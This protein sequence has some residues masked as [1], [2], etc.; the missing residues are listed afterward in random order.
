VHLA[1]RL[2]GDLGDD[3]ETFGVE[4]VV[5]RKYSL[6]DCPARRWSLPRAP[7][8]WRRSFR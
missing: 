5:G 2:R 6:V 7:G 8:R 1:P 4:H 3:L